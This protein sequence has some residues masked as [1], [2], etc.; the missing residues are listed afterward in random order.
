MNVCLFHTNHLIEVLPYR[1][2]DL[3]I[4]KIYDYKILLEVLEVSPEERAV[5]ANLS[6][7]SMIALASCMA[8]KP[9]PPV[10]TIT[11]SRCRVAFFTEPYAASPVFMFAFQLRRHQHQQYTQNNRLPVGYLLYV[12]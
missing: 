6:V 1:I 3:R 12:F 7:K 2:F 4:I 8:I 9:N 11:T 5:M 10:P